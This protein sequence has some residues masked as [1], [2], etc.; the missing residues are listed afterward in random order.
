MSVRAARYADAL[1]L[2]R[3]APFLE[4]ATLCGYRHHDDRDGSLAGGNS[5]LGIGTISGVRCVALV[6]NAAIKGGTIS[7]WGL[8]KVL[9]AQTIALENRPDI[10]Q[11]ATPLPNTPC[12]ARN[13]PAMGVRVPKRHSPIWW[14]VAAGP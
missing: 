3:G 11:G 9:R 14:G 1:L 2:D 10:K 8:Q 7:P 5:I 4:L 6:H 13:K 12:P